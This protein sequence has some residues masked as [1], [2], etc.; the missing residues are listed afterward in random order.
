[1]RSLIPVVRSVTALFFAVFGYF[2][3]RLTVGVSGLTGT[4]VGA[5]S[6][7]AIVTCGALIV[8]AQLAS[9]MAQK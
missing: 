6:T 9:G 5:T 2:A 4:P 8:L 1:M 7:A 3:V